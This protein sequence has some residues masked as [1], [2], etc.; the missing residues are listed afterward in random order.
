VSFSSR[1]DG[2]QRP[3]TTAASGLVGEGALAVL[4][5]VGEAYEVRLST[6][7]T[8]SWSR[9][10]G[11]ASCGSCGRT[12][13]FQAS[14]GSGRLQTVELLREKE[15]IRSDKERKREGWGQVSAALDLWFDGRGANSGGGASV[16]DEQSSWIGGS[17]RGRTKGRWR[18]GVRASYSRGLMAN[19]L[20]EIKG[21][22]TL[23]RFSFQ[24][25]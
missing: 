4:E 1:C 11:V 24:R 9:R 12:E 25:Q 5:V 3:E 23:A 16:S 22:V 6:V 7:K 15:R 18:R 17:S 10:S 19:Y 2:E 8:S 20:R 13:D 14:G 21:G